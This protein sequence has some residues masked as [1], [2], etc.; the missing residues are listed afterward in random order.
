MSPPVT[1]PPAPLPHRALCPS[2]PQLCS[3]GRGQPPK[4]KAV[5][6]GSGATIQ[7]WPLGRHQESTV[8]IEN[9]SW[10]LR[11]DLVWEKARIPG[12]CAAGLWGPT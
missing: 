6:I 2:S 8:V 7:G 3:G 11:W 5:E 12:E 10:N 9:I 4:Q 1:P